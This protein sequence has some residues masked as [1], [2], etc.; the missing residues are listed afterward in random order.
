MTVRAKGGQKEEQ[1]AFLP[2][3]YGR[4][5]ACAVVDSY[6]EDTEE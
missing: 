4:P 1:E 3:M 6:G 5:A 2:V